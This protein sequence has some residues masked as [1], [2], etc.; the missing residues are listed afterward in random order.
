MAAMEV[1]PVFQPVKVGATLWHLALAAA[2]VVQVMEP[3]SLYLI[4]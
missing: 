2:V 3:M 4:H 1:T